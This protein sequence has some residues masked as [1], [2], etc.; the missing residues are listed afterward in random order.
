[1]RAGARV[2]V[3][4][5]AAAVPDFSTL[6][7]GGTR[8][9]DLSDSMTGSPPTRFGDY[10]LLEEIGQGGMGSVYR[11][12]QAGFN[13]VVALKMIRAGRFASRE[14]VRRFQSEAEAAG[15]LDHPHIVPL[16][17]VGECDGRH[18]FSMKLVA[19]GS[20]ASPP[21]KLREP[22]A[23]AAL[24]AAVARAVHH[25]HQRGILHR[26]LK[27]SNILLDESCRPY[28][29][30][31]GLAKQSGRDAGLTASE[32]VIGTPSYMAPELA[33]GGARRATVAADV[34]G[35]GAVLYE[36]LTGRPPFQAETRLETLRRVQES[37]P[38]GVRSVNR[39][40]DRDLETICFKCL[41][42]DPRRRYGSAE[43]LAE[44]LDRWRAHEPIRARR[45]SA[46]QRL[47][48]W[49][50]RRP[51]VAALLAVVCLAS[52]ALS[53]G[54]FWHAYRLRVALDVARQENA[55]AQAVTEFLQDV[56]KLASP[57]NAPG[58][59]ISIEEAL[60]QAS[61]SVGKK[62][63]G[64]PLI[65][66]EIRS[67][68]GSI[69]AELS[70]LEEAELQHT[71]ALEIRRSMLG[72]EDPDTLSSRHELARALTE[73]ALPLWAR[74]HA[75]AAYD[76]RCRRLGKDDLRT[77]ESLRLLAWTWYARAQYAQ[78]EPMHREV[79]EARRRE[80]GDENQDTFR[81][82]IDLANTIA[83]Q[84]RHE[85]AQPLYRKA[86]DGLRQTTG[87]DSRYTLNALNTFADSLEALGDFAEVEKCRREVLEGRK[88]SMRIEHPMTCNAMHRLGM[89]YMRRGRLDEAQEQFEEFLRMQI[90]SGRETYWGTCH[91]LGRL[92][93][94]YERR[95]DHANAR[96]LR[97][98]AMDLH[99]RDEPPDPGRPVLRR[100]TPADGQVELLGTVDPSLH[101]VRG[102]WQF[103]GGGNVGVEVAPS[104]QSL[105]AMPVRVQGS[106]ELEVS[107]TRTSGENTVILNFPVGAGGATLHLSE[108]QG[109]KS[110]LRDVWCRGV[111]DTTTAG[112]GPLVSG[113]VH[114]LRVTVW[115]GGPDA[116]VEAEVDGE[117]RI[118][119][120]AGPQRALCPPAFYRLPPGLSLGLGAHNAPVVF[121][122]VKLR[123]FEGEASVVK[124]E[125]GQFKDDWKKPG[126]ARGASVSPSPWLE[127]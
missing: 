74:P 45:V 35:L 107:F 48:Q 53:A 15:T 30:D 95:G 75:Q 86:V 55:R 22:K 36:M 27:P 123:L 69:Y 88:R 111:F 16:Y 58:R 46:P 79:L 122:S 44:D 90:R 72:E 34:Y 116:R 125:P 54:G 5:A 102:R 3:P 104:L 17:E 38:S 83:A 13:R 39:K 31:F 26:D 41:S 9:G 85:E 118:K 89:F 32:A 7:G 59:R 49:S 80:L 56:L 61:G 42:K 62:F 101:V 57:D 70:K 73:Q 50:R 33:A 81:S 68:I 66:A 14:E 115:L 103:T 109:Q 76:G 82:T 65:E 78:A 43:S 112:K 6:V 77:I 18:F 94:A 12:R 113:K 28:V 20:L 84:G 117:P 121:H 64:Q 87:P 21:A 105:L 40:V 114:V 8:D 126:A 93:D 52:V 98:L 11:A 51:A 67:I 71:L 37:E 63:A 119:P 97:L 127:D 10:E 23:A 91:V 4:V 92:G 99:R 106:Y 120:W 108:L 60:D 47:W 24:V 2:A 29:T 96:G 19:G 1:M 25:A 124:V 100:F 110:Y